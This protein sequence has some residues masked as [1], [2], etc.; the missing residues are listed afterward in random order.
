MCETMSTEPPPIASLADRLRNVQVGTRQELEPSRHVFRGLPSYVVLDPVTFQAHQFSIQDYQVFVRLDRQRPL[1]EV[2][3]TLVDE[4][5]LARERENDFYHFIVHLNQ[6]GLLNLPV[7]NAKTLYARFEKRQAARRRNRILGCLFL[8]VPLCHPDAFLK[9]TVRAVAP[10]F[11]RGAFVL[12]LIA[13]VLGVTVVVTRWEEFRDPLGTMLAMKNLPILWILLVTL[14]VGHELG[15]AY[16]CK[17]FG[18][19]VPE[20]GAYF[21]LFTPCAYVDASAAWGFT[22]RVHRVVVSLAGMYFESIAALIALAVW[23]MTGPT[24]IHSAAHYVIILSTVV[25]IGFN[26][27]PLMRYDGYYIFSDLVNVPNLRQLASAQTI[28]TLKR[29]LFGIRTRPVTESRKGQL[30]LFVFGVASALYK[31]SVLLGICAIIAMKIPAIGLGIGVSYIGT[32]FWK[33]GVTL[34]RYV[35]WSEE[36]APVRFRAVLAASLLLAACPLCLLVL[37][38]PGSVQS[39]GIV[40]RGNDRIVRSTGTGFLQE[41]RVQVGDRVELGTVLCDLS[42]IDITSAI[43]GKQAE[44]GRLHGQLLEEARSD[45]CAAVMTERRL[46]Q[47]QQERR[48]LAALEAALTVQSPVTGRITQAEGLEDVGRLVRKGERLAQVS[49]G[50][51]ILNAVATEGA[52]S[53]SV[54]QAGDR[55]EIRLVGHAGPVFHGTVTNLAKAGSR[56]IDDASLT[57]LGGGSIAV[58]EMT[59][60]AKQAFFRITIAIDDPDESV[61]RHG[62]TAMA[63]FPGRRTSLGIHLYRR[64]LQFLNHLRVAG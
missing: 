63:T 54:P 42:N 25:T 5:V 26:I 52:L 3:E 50:P 43:R 41:P 21:I 48:Q 7:S 32:T 39:V 55:V 51:W 8:R 11:T 6:L 16:A 9:K 60:E 45:R 35:G 2:F 58:S 61:L 37:P 15:H 62:M 19:N 34:V 33:L 29:R 1:G 53:T 18:G 31:F 47:A 27:N 10:L 36:V 49:A 38:T 28:A 64:L 14:K 59:M 23:C 20:M 12:W 4:G 13:L 24:A 22:N 30:G 44:I 40:G 46:D 17:H 56:K 57:H